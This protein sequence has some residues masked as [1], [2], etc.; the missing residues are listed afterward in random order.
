MTTH[1]QQA[2]HPAYRPDIDG[3]RAVAVLSVVGYHAFPGWIPG[4]FI[5]VDIFFVISGF[6]IS[7]ILLAQLQAGHFSLVDFYARRVRRIFPA[8]LIILAAVLGV[9]FFVL[10]PGEYL[11]LAKHA[12]GGAGFIVNLLQQKET[13]YFSDSAEN[14]PLLHLWSLGVEEQFYILWP[15]MLAAAWRWKHRA[16][17][18]IGAAFIASCIASMWFVSRGDITADFYSP[19]SRFWELMAGAILAWGMQHGFALRSRKTCDALVALALIVIVASVFLLNK[20]MTFPGWRALLPVLAAV[21]VIAAGKHSFIS[22]KMIANRAAVAVGLIS[23]PLYLW[24]WPLL[25]YAHIMLGEDASRLVRIGVVCLSFGLAAFTYK[26][27]EQPIRRGKLKTKPILAMLMLM[28]LTG[29]VSSAIYAEQG[30]PAR[31]AFMGNA[32]Q[33]LDTDRLKNI[34][35]IHAR[36]G[37]CHLQDVKED[38]QPPQCIESKKPLLLLWGDSHAA[39]LYPGLKKLQETNNFGIAQ[40]TQSGCPPIFD[41]PKL[42]FRANCNDIN[43]RIFGQ[44][45]ELK[46]DVI[47]LA[48]AWI[49]EDYP[50]DDQDTIARLLKTI[51]Q[52]KQAA[53]QAKIIVVGPGPRWL[54]PMPAIYRHALN[55]A[56]V[57][58]PAYSLEHRDLDL[59]RM[60]GE[61]NEK[62]TTA[63]IEYLRPQQYLCNPS[64]CLTRYGEG[65]DSLAFI[66][67]EHITAPVSEALVTKLA[68]DILGGLA[69]A[70]NPDQFKDR[71]AL[72]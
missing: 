2:D 62:L 57:L 37:A 12:A 67:R 46:P 52:I 29:G 65:F 72:R 50:M 33:A 63:G 48:A 34:W 10:W 18:M 53:P 13:D 15:L 64:G 17:A 60:D 28:L 3:L 23:Y 43:R 5:G 49:H 47:L 39:A 26:F 1:A 25:S 40:L 71:D 4:G 32:V 20:N 68:P 66:D 19:F 36:V 27:V 35:Q 61:M 14:Q 45:P 11:H 56:H 54:T 58:P 70:Q 55:F 16:S 41:I 51:T 24:H 22:K 59:V 8:L 42:K 7:S 6:L 9:G 38:Q 30:L 21:L 44:L 31:Y 69:I